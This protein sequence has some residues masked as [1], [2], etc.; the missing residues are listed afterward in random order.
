MKTA[1][2][3]RDYI[4]GLNRQGGVVALDIETT[5][6][7]RFKDKLVSVQLCAAGETYAVYFDAEN[8]AELHD[9]HCPL[10]FHNFKFDLAFLLQ[11]HVDLTKNEI[12]DTM[13]LH[14]LLNENLAHDLDSIVQERW[15]DPYKEV[16]WG[17]NKSFHEAP[18]QDKI[19]YAGKD[20]VYTGLLFHRLRDELAVSGVPEKL[21]GHA[22]KLAAALFKTEVHGV[23]VDLDYLTKIGADLTTKIDAAR[24]VMRAS[25]PEAEL[26]ETELWYKELEKRKT[27]KG[28]ANVKR[29]AFNWDSGPQLQALIYG[30][31]GVKVVEKRNKKT[32]EKRPTLDDEALERLQGEHPVIDMLRNYRGDQKVFGSFIEGTLERQ[33]G[34]RVYPSFNVNGTVT[35]RISSS[36]PNMQQLP[37]EGGVRGIYVPDEGQKLLSSDFCQLEVVGEAHFS[38]DKNL[39]KIILEGASKHDIT[40]ESLGI[41][42][43]L[44][45]TV[46]FAMQYLCSHYKVAQ[47]LGVSEKEGRYAWEKYWETYSGSKAIVDEC[48]AKVDRGEPI[49]SLFGRRRR[50][51]KIFESAGAKEAAYRQ[52]YSSLIQGSC[53]DLTHWAFYTVSESLERS[54]LGRALFEV[55]DEIIIQAAPQCIEAARGVLV[56][57][58]VAAG[59][60][61][62]LSLPLSTDCSEPLDRWQKG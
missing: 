32:R 13:L 24:L 8:V 62:G 56:D 4:E 36:N 9:L 43:Q 1:Q 14:H 54:G 33:V 35:G 57:T 50:F 51:P 21:C 20:V 28:R 41:K 30:E 38:H 10:V 40:A 52:A 19:E 26:V 42:R 11:Y 34:G 46:N 55:H 45:K 12:W 25:V 17:R 15:N 53:A 18:E 58:M 7:D 2:G 37:R 31:L 47:I 48:K 44:A 3:L 5:G 27:P 60:A 29:P 16:F 59:P 22:R 6:L 49:V 23:R 39:L 61:N